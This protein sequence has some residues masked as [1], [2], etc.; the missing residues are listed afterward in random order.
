MMK[1]KT[2]CK[3]PSASSE[4]SVQ[5]SETVCEMRTSCDWSNPRSIFSV[6]VSHDRCLIRHN[7]KVGIDNFRQLLGDVGE[8]LIVS[9]PG[10]LCGV[11][12]KSGSFAQIIPVRAIR[13]LISSWEWQFNSLQCVVFIC[14]QFVLFTILLYLMWNAAVYRQ[15]VYNALDKIRFCFICICTTRA[16][17]Y[18]ERKGTFQYGS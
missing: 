13:H 4:Y 2:S 9:L 8:H 1:M 7:R 17:Q 5:L 6:P 11:Y 14:S 10:F 18:V 15:W 12:I 3:A 16:L